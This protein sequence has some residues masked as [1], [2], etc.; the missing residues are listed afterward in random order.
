M[1]KLRVVL[2]GVTG[3]GA[4]YLRMLMEKA[5]DIGTELVGVVQPHEPG[6]EN[7]IANV[8][9]AGIPV[10]ENLQALYNSVGQVD[11]TIVASPIHFHYE[12]CFEALDN[13]SNVLCEK[14]AV[15]VYSQAL[16][17]EKVAREKNLQLS[18][19][20]PKSFSDAFIRLKKDAVEGRFGKAVS[21]RSL[22]LTSKSMEEYR[23]SSWQGR[24]YDAEGRVVM[25]GIMH[26]QASHQVHAML[27]LLGKDIESSASIQTVCG[28][29]CR[30]NDI[31]SY[32]TAVMRLTTEECPSVMCAAT[33]AYAGKE[34]FHVRYE[35]EHA[36]LDGEL[37][38]DS[39]LVVHCGDE[40]IDYG[41]LNHSVE[42]RLR[43]TCNCIREGKQ[44]PCPISSAKAEVAA[45][46]GLYLSAGCVTQVPKQ[47]VQKYRGIPT[48]PDD[49]RTYRTSKK[50]C[51]KLEKCFR[52]G[53]LPSEMG[54]PFGEPPKLVTIQ[55]ITES[56]YRVD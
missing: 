43:V 45:V 54:K 52:S 14:P 48:S 35:W 9:A 40:D 31:Q 1:E 32:D 25:D 38:R 50:I 26:G 23:A 12:Q 19:A 17:L 34:T 28:E 5:D 41:P 13:R 37:G 22:V 29:W 7:A 56:N 39:T 6:T 21:M 11:L 18:F 51:S 44:I 24:L 53:L 16:I 42:N 55:Q 46:D 49:G 3:Y 8:A 4:E 33:N 36:Y 30:V 15:S 47:K 27:A 20:Y 10:A 2:S